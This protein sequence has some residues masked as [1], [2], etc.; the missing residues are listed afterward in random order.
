MHHPEEDDLLSYASGTNE[1]WLS[2]VVACHLTYCPE[3]RRE[4]ELLD[5]LGGGL[6]D[7]LDTSNAGSSMVTASELRS[8]PERRDAPPAAPLIPGLPHPLGPYL[9]KGRPTW[10]FLAPGLRQI[11]LDFSVG[12]V[13]ARVIRFAPGFTIPEHRHQGLEMVLVLDGVLRDGASGEI[14]RTGDLSRRE[15]DTI[16]SQIIGRDEPCTCLVVS[17]APVVPSTLMG[18]ILKAI[19]GV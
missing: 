12:A 2:L 3:C 7:S 17:A 5:D 8:R 4:V 10:K 19:T 13:P 6:L 9:P 18:K 16:H 15:A 1:E 11:P 14:F